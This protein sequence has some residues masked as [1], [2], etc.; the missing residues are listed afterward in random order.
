MEGT[1]GGEGI[2]AE[3]SVLMKKIIIKKHYIIKAKNP[4]CCIKIRNENLV[5]LTS[6]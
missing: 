6:R 4:Q 3:S 5:Q 2:Q 1:A